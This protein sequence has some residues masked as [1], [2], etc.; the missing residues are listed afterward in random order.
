MKQMMIMM[1]NIF[2]NEK[3]GEAIKWEEEYE[4]DGSFRANLIHRHVNI[5]INLIQFRDDPFSK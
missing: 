2:V 3:D 5:M 4:K 1:M